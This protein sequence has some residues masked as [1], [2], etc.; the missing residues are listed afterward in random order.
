MPRESFRNSPRYENLPSLHAGIHSAFLQAPLGFVCASIWVHVTC[1]LIVVI[2]L[3]VCTSELLEIVFYSSSL[4][5]LLCMQQVLHTLYGW[6]AIIFRVKSGQWLCGQ[7]QGCQDCSVGGTTAFSTNGVGKNAYPHAKQM[8][9]DPWF[10]GL[11]TQSCLTLAIPWILAIPPGSLSMGFSRQEYWG[12]LPFPSP[13]WTLTLWYI[14]NSKWVKDLNI[15]AKAIRLFEEN[16]GKKL[17]N[18]GVS[19]VSSVPQL[20]PTLCVPAC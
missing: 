15:R 14:Q 16:I 5:K 13:S 7:W 17:H 1:C 8:K 4:S 12:G 18:I 6:F 2:W 19:S 20:C 11:V 3:S 9:L 10:G